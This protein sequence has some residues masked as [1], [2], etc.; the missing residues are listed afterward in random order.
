MAS[1]AAKTSYATNRLVDLYI[2]PL[3]DPRRALVELR[4]LIETRPATDAAEH[5]RRSLA[6]LKARMNVDSLEES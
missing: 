5:A 1:A 3:N 4:R 2:G 6:D